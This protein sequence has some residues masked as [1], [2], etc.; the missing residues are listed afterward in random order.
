MY[1]KRRDKFGWKR[2]DD[3]AE[4]RDWLLVNADYLM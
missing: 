2:D 4:R 3:N 1:R